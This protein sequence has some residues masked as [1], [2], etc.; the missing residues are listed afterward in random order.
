MSKAEKS[1]QHPRVILVAI[2][3]SEKQGTMAE[4][5]FDIT[6]KANGKKMESSREKLN[7]WRDIHG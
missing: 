3:K 4:A 2:V 6:L 7:E 1:F 5:N